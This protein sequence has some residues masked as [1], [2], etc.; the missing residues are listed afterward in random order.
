MQENGIVGK[1]GPEPTARITEAAGWREPYRVFEVTDQSG[2]R[3]GL[4]QW[5]ASD[6]VGD[7][8]GLALHEI[9]LAA[10]Q[11]EP[12]APSVAP[13]SSAPRLA[14]DRPA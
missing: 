1:I 3:H 5:L 4:V 2:R 9:Y 7:N 14:A 11:A 10:T 8:F 6:D 12:S 13:E